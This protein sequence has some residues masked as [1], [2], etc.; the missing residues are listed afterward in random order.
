MRTSSTGRIDLGSILAID[1]VP[2]ASISD[3]N[4]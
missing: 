1:S 3:W 2:Y 4:G